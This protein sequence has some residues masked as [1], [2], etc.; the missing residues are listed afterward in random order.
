MFKMNL[1]KKLKSSYQIKL[2]NDGQFLCH[3]MESKTVVY[4]ANSWEKV[5]ELRKPK[6]PGEI[7]FSKNNNYLY[8]KNSIGT[9]CVYETSEFSLIKTLKSN[10]T[11][12]MNEGDF[13]LTNDVFVIIDTLNTNSGNQLAS[14]NLDNGKYNI[15]T[16]FEDSIT[17][18]KFEQYIT[19]EDCYL[20]TLSYDNEYQD[21]REYNLLKVK[22]ENEEASINIIIHPKRIYWDS[23]IYDPIHN[24]YILVSDFEIIILDSTFKKVLR[25]KNILGKMRN[26]D[27][28]YFN[29]FNQSKNAKFLILTYSEKIIIL[30]YDDLQIIAEEHISYASCAEFSDDTRY[31]FIGTW[32]NGYILENNFK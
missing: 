3:T 2:S 30:S 12:Q 28:G 21:Y 31:L 11:L 5:A 15:L 32:N 27:F 4:N 10:K 9:I 16:E 1:V 23:V 20:F 17:V 13:A 7:K 18:F 22:Y 8:I 24:V 19:N 25:E 6:N 29:H 26:E 14:I